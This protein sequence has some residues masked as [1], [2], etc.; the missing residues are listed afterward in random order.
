MSIT[1][2]KLRIIYF[3]RLKNWFRIGFLLQLFLQRQLSSW[4]TPTHNLCEQHITDIADWL[5]MWSRYT[6]ERTHRCRLIVCCRYLCAGS[7]ILVTLRQPA[8]IYSLLFQLST[9]FP[10]YR[11]ILSF[12]VLFN[13]TIVHIRGWRGWKSPLVRGVHTLDEYEKMDAHIWERLALALCPLWEAHLSH[14]RYSISRTTSLA[15]SM[16]FDF[17]NLGLSWERTRWKS[18]DMAVVLLPSGHLSHWTEAYYM[19]HFKYQTTS[20]HYVM[21]PGDKCDL[22]LAHE[23]TSSNRIE[24]FEIPTL[25][26]KETPQ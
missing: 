24:V 2:I 26:E 4:N 18:V 15:P 16:N 1:W 19:Y 17:L 21:L 10:E 3:I 5:D 9:L 7:T 11:N 22:C 12:R 20:W 14:S 13:K 8:H 25:N 23:S 6:D